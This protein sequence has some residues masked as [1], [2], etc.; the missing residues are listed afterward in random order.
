MDPDRL[1]AIPL[2]AGL[3]HAQRAAVAAVAREVRRPTGAILVE[4][5]E[6]GFELF[7]LEAGAVEVI[8]DGEQVAM[9]RAGDV[10]GE[11]AVL[12]RA[13]RG[14]SVV[15]TAPVR[16]LVLTAWDLKRL[17]RSA[18]S[19]AARLRDL[20]VARENGRTDGHQPQL[21]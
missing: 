16:L 6:F 19:V 12:Q 5:G 9:L 8:C 18:P 13:P 15:A 3:D 14:A 10:F 2:F 7:A 4:Q 20:I 1:L 21:Q 17:T 11:S